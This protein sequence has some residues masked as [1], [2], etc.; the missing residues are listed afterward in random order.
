MMTLKILFKHNI[1]VIDACS[2]FKLHIVDRESR[3]PVDDLVLM[4]V[5][6]AE[7]DAGRVEDGARLGEDVVV[8]V[9]HQVAAARVLHHETHVLLQDNNQQKS[10]QTGK[11]PTRTV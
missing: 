3:L 7:D 11:S 1:F 8:D 2:I 6:Q 10:I 9:Y 4:Q 5:L